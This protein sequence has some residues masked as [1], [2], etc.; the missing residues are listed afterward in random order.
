VL[1][2]PGGN[3]QFVGVTHLPLLRD[4]MPAIG[5][6]TRHTQLTAHGR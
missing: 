2:P 6:L 1:F 3:A 4:R 5:C